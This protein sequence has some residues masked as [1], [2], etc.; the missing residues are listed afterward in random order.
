MYRK[1]VKKAPPTIAIQELDLNKMV[2][3]FK[4]GRL[5]FISVDSNGRYRITSPE[6]GIVNN[7][8]Q[9]RVT[10]YL[11]HHGKRRRI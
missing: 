3:G 9:F 5:Y 11:T 1:V 10:I 2:V 7:S 8:N 6:A 4:S